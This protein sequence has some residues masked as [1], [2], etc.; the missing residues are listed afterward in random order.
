MI[1]HKTARELMYSWH[2]GQTDPIYAA[3]SSGLV[4]DWD[5]LLYSIEHGVEDATDRAKLMEYIKHKQGKAKHCYVIMD[6]RFYP[7]PWVSRSYGMPSKG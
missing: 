7:L 6:Q 3:A 1:Q 5:A 2:C 4:A